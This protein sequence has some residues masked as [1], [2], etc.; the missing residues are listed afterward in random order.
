MIH[1]AACQTFSINAP[2]T[3]PYSTML[4]KPPLFYNAAHTKLYFIM[5]LIQNLILQCSSYQTLY[6]SQTFAWSILNLIHCQVTKADQDKRSAFGWKIKIDEHFFSAANSQTL[7]Q[8]S[9]SWSEL[10]R[11]ILANTCKI[12]IIYSELSRLQ[13]FTST[14]IAATLASSEVEKS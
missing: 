12:S 14:I 10:A 7:F 1:Q 4:L 2:H 6:N 11:P 3:K 5:L 9:C 8:S 13:I